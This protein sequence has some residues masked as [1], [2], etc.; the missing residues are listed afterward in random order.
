MNFAAEA[1]ARHEHEPL[2]S[3]REL[4]AE[5]HHHAAAERM[6]HERRALVAE[7]DHE[8]ANATRVCAE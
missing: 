3:L 2:A 4:V 8:I 1:A 6:P 5:L 7:G